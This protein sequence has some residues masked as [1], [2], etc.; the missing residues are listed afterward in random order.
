MNL[1]KMKYYL[2]PK[3]WKIIWKFLFFF[4]FLFSKLLSAKIKVNL[5]FDVNGNEFDSNEQIARKTE[6]ILNY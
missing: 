5:T 6:D 2:E 4:V 3:I 1:F